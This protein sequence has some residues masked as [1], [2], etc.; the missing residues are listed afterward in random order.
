M[1]GSVISDGPEQTRTECGIFAY[2]PQLRKMTHVEKSSVSAAVS[3]PQQSELE[4]K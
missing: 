4:N 3:L 1:T 2:V